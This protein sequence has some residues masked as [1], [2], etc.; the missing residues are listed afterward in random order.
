MNNKNKTIKYE[1]PFYVR[2]GDCEHTQLPVYSSMYFWA[3]AGEMQQLDNLT[4]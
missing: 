2:E 4:K 3:T 1:K